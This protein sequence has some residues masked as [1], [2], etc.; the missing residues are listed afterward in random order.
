[1]TCYVLDW[2][3]RAVIREEYTKHIPFQPGGYSVNM[4]TLATLPD[5]V[6]ILICRYVLLQDI[7]HLR[8]T[9]RRLAAFVLSN[10]IY[11][12]QSVARNTFPDFNR[13][14]RVPESGTHDFSWL[15]SL[16]PKFFAAFLV[17]KLREVYPDR[18]YDRYGIP[19]ES[20]WGD[21]PR[22]RV[23]TGLR[24]FKQ[25]SDI[26]QDVY[27]LPDSCVPRRPRRPVK[28]RVSRAVRLGYRSVSN[29]ALDLVERR[30]TLV[31]QRRLVYLNDLD[32]QD[33]VDYIFMF[34]IL[35]PAFKSNYDGAGFRYAHNI[36]IKYDGPSIFDWG[37]DDGKRLSQG[38]SWV[39]SFLLNQGPMLFWH[40]WYN[41]KEEYEVKDVI[42]RAWSERSSER[43]RIERDAASSVEEALTSLSGR[44]SVSYC[45]CEET[46]EPFVPYLK[47]TIP[48]LRSSP[49][50]PVKEVME[51][52]PYWIN[53]RTQ[54]RP[55]FLLP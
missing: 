55:D 13:L 21:G 49:F 39:N 33:I 35:L 37:K 48:H 23:E 16:V 53:F 52:I 6:L 42:L 32:R 40:Q 4:H 46:L 5:D 34:T 47:H 19:A 38:N 9:S 51:D 20:E 7:F 54:D 45:F 44:E 50:I 25:L 15:K 36:S 43:I 18:F 41:R 28:E 30:E 31:S 2:F 10:D 11:I 8:Q 24:V 1:L 3:S 17:D 26:S 22:A 12:S 14:L 27:K 29:G